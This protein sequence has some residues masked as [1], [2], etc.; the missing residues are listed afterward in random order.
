M[1]HQRSLLVRW[2]TLAIML[3]AGGWTI[4]HLIWNFAAQTTDD[5]WGI[6]LIILFF[7]SLILTFVQFLQERS[8]LKHTTTNEQLPEPVIAKFF[9]TSS[10]SATLWF[11]IRMEV[12]AQWL[13]SGW[14]KIQSPAWGIS[15]KAL[16][17]FATTSLAKTAGPNPAVQAWYAWFLHQLVQPHLGIFSF[18]VTYGEF[19]VGLGILLGVL[20]GLAA[21]FGVLMNLNYLL[22]GS[23]SI[24]PVL[25]LF[26]LFLL[27]S[28]RVCGLLGGDRWL[29]PTLGLPWKPGS[30]FR[31]PT[32]VTAAS[33]S[34]PI[35][36]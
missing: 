16:S 1:L 29:F 17:T 30:W 10:G 19:A 9:L 12:G 15:G 34:Q 32:V 4:F 7:L 2:S 8:A 25:A 27:L 28:W 24:N 11:V 22:A 23:V 5:Y 13:V 36:S 3:V 18:L 35:T 26:G 14:K 33:S 31:P 20:T 21:S 6:A